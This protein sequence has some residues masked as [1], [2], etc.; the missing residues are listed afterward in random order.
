MD[1]EQPPDDP[2][3]WADLLQRVVGPAPFGFA[4]Y[5]P[6][7]TYVM[8]NEALAALN[9]LP[10]EAHRGRSV[11][12]VVPDL[13]PAIIALVDRVLADGVPLID[14]ELAGESGGAPGR[15]GIWL[16]SFYRI[17]A[18]GGE[19]VGVAALVRDVTAQRRLEA[20][21][22][23]EQFRVAFDALL[24]P[25]I[26]VRA[27]PGN[28][29]HVELRIDHLNPAAVESTGL[30][31]EDALGRCLEDVFPM[32]D[33]LGLGPAYRRVL[34]DGRP[35]VARGLAY[36][37]ER[38]DGPA[39]GR[40]DISVSA[41]PGGL[42]ITWRDSELEHRLAE[43]VAALAV[44]RRRVSRLQRAFLPRA[45]PAA[46]GAVV[47][48]RYRSAETDAPLGGDW[49][50]ALRLGDLLWLSVGDVAGHGMGAVEVM[51]VARF[52]ARAYVVEDPEP[53]RVLQ[54][55][56][57]YAVLMAG[58]SP[59]RPLV[60]M[61]AASYEPA[62]RR[63]R[64]ANA[65]H[66]PPVVVDRSGARLLGTDPHPPVGVGAGGHRSHQVVLEAGSRLVLYTDG[67]I[68]RRDEDLDRGLAR[69]LAIASDLPAD[70]E[71][72]CDVLLERC[73]PADGTLH[74]DVGLL[75]MVVG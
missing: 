44:E 56:D 53:A 52:T 20:H 67:L 73:L 2:G 43:H 15:R 21:L 34:V 29:G 16:N 11:T 55:L 58:L 37:V 42:V 51:G 14:V 66:P 8:V 39:E 3:G 19:V 31:L 28:A 69:L 4:L 47:A 9:G 27:V 1:Q 68:E 65:G 10:A 49:Y 62:A 61:V 48:G 17:A 23:T 12:E 33:T 50:D 41:I 64:W 36:T 54:R 38:P 72:A 30:R 13:A 32:V 22:A 24:E 70:A 25:S 6:D 57:R 35:F 71:A 5:R 63:L 18:A 40:V 26:M 46:P 75:V 60:T 59:I 45:L 7:H 74:D